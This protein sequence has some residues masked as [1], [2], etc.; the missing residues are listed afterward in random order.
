MTPAFTPAEQVI[1]NLLADGKPH[2][3]SEIWRC[4]PGSEKMTE[5][6]MKD[7]VRDNANMMLS[8]I[9]RKL[10]AAGESIVCVVIQRRMYYQ[11]V[12]GGPFVPSNAQ[13]QLAPC[14]SD[15]TYLG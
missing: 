8:S 9:R 4:V 1:L 6:Q 14:P 3:R 11:R 12:R 7:L 15:D 5:Q 2:L 10:K 13:F